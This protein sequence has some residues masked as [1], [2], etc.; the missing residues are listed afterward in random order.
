MSIQQLG[1]EMNVLLHDEPL[2][3]TGTFEIR[4]TVTVNVSAQEARRQVHRWLLLEVSHMMG[5]EEPTLI[6]GDETCWRVPVHLS[7]P[8]RGI[9][10]QV[11]FVDINAINGELVDPLQQKTGIEQQAQAMMANQPIFQHKRLM[12]PAT[13]PDSVSRAPRIILDENDLPVVIPAH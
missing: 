8:Q 13:V 1:Q 2:I 11:G 6:V 10:G 5:A 7:T 9:I 4:R 3:H 12:F